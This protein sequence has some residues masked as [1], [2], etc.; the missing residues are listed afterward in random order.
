MT[1]LKNRT[2][3]EYILKCVSLFPFHKFRMTIMCVESKWIDM[4]ANKKTDLML[5]FLINIVSL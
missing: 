4:Y 5:H 3:L 2:L 1:F